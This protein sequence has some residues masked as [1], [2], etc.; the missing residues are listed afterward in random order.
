MSEDSELTHRVKHTRKSEPEKP[1]PDVTP[2]KPTVSCCSVFLIILISLFVTMVAILLV[3]PSHI[4]PTPYVI[5]DNPPEFDPNL[6]KI[7]KTSEKLKVPGCECFAVDSKGF[8]YS[9]TLNG[10]VVKISP[11]FS[12]VTPI[13]RTGPAPVD[14]V[15]CNTL[16]EGYLE[17]CGIVLG[18]SVLNDDTLLV[19]DVLHGI[20]SVSINRKSKTQLLDL[21]HQPD[22]LK[23]TIGLPNNIVVLQDEGA[24]LFSDSTSKFY[25]KNVALA[26]FEHGNDGIIYR[27]DLSTQKITALVSG[28][29]FPNGV[30]LHRDGESVLICE[31]NI[32]RITRFYF[33]GEKKGKREVFV[34]NLIGTPDNIQRSRQGGYWVAVPM[35]REWPY[36]SDIVL[37][38]PFI[39]KLFAKLISSDFLRSTTKAQAGHFGLAVRLGENGEVLEY[40]FDPK[41]EHVSVVTHALDLSDGYLYFGTSAEEHLVRTK[42]PIL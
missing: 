31:F 4:S 10:L 16:D 23:K 14:S 19:V 41:G 26:V 22:Y 30:E 8:I 5:S 40:V 37:K 15:E 18:V 36:I 21:K 12:T 34:D 13:V 2:P 7:V 11:D 29:H 1:I 25:F 32:A 17:E 3:L 9:G 24:F 38:Y 42:Y 33:K 6:T 27:Y 28:L 35:I 20:F 39:S